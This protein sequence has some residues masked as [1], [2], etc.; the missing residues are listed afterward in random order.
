MQIKRMRMFADQNGSGKSTIF[1]QIKEKVAFGFYLNADD[2]ELNVIRV[3]DRV[4]K[5]GHSVCEDK[6]RKRYFKS[7]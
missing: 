6:I 4:F 7:L 5:G 2:V 1:N 3:K